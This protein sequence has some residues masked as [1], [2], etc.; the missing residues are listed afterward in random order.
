MAPEVPDEQACPPALL[1]VEDDEQF[2]NFLRDVLGRH[3]YEV[4]AAGDGNEALRLFGV[5]RP[6][7]VITDLVMPGV[8]GLEL[9]IELRKSDPSL[10]ILAISGGMVTAPQS[11][12]KVAGALGA[13]AVLEKPF[14]AEALIRKVAEFVGTVPDPTRA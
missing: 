14:Y 6:D 8:D 4:D 10:P 1:V 9:V 3:G 5:R 12:L 11:Y 7:M 13:N 2:R